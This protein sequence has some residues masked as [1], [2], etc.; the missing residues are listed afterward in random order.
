MAR[1]YV[2]TLSDCPEAITLIKKLNDWEDMP[3]HDEELG[4]AVSIY[5]SLSVTG[6]LPDSEP[7]PSPCPWPGTY[8]YM[9]VRDS[10]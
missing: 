7:C 3:H 4:L 6:D 10:A 1:K 8:G 2:R 5:K 9:D